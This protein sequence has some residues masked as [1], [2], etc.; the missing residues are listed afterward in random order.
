LINQKLVT[1]QV[2][3][4]MISSQIKEGMKVKINRK[5]S[6]SSIELNGKVG[7][8]IEVYN[9][10]VVLDIEPNPASGVWFDEIELI[11]TIERNLPSWW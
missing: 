6:Q 2:G 11:P 10:Y 1:Y 4:K 5:R 8:I 7:T 3:G 9:G